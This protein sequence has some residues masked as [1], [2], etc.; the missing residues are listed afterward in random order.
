MGIFRRIRIRRRRALLLL[1][2]LLVVV[3]WLLLRGCARAADGPGKFRVSPDFDSANAYRPAGQTFTIS[4]RDL[5]LHDAS[6]G[7]DLDIRVYYPKSSGP[8]SD[9]FPLLIFSHGLGGSRAVGPALLGYWASHGYVVIAPTHADSV[10]ERQKRGAPVSFQSGL[11]EFASDPAARIGRAQDD[12]FIIGSLAGIERQIPDL[13]GRID[14]E[15]IG[16]GGHSAGAMTAVMLGGAQLDM[17]A[18]GPGGPE[19]ESRRDDRIDCIL[20]LSGQGVGGAIDTHTWE[21]IHIPMLVMTGSLD[22]SS[23]TRQTAQSRQDPYTYA[24]PGD[25]Y[26]LF[27][28]GAAHMS[29]TGKAAGEEG[30]GRGRALNAALGV[31]SAA[32]DSVDDFD[33]L[34]IFNAVQTSSLAYWDAYLRD[35]KPALNYL[36]SA[37]LARMRNPAIDYQYK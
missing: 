9:R 6:R 31:D 30:A 26:L 21:R 17:P 35:S 32:L 24:P 36:Q 10:Q 3:L 34:A 28:A 2:L 12:S 27:I 11:A 16:M 29:F 14:S 22:S 4:T 19:T 7:K 20:V 37:Q 18:N 5:T 15:R 1:P 13:Q 25:K 8:S 33:Q 23:R